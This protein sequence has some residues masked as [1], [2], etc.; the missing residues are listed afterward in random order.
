VRQISFSP[1][2]VQKSQIIIKL[3]ILY[4]SYFQPKLYPASLSKLI[5]GFEMILNDHMKIFQ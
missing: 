1:G 4:L 3:K 2:N 5:S